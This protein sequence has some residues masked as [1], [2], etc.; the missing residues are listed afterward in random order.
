LITEA[1]REGKTIVEY[2]RDSKSSKALQRV[3]ER[4]SKILEELR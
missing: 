1:Q 3:C 4:F 2:S